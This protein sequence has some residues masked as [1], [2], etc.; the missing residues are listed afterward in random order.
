MTFTPVIE[1]ITSQCEARPAHVA[2]VESGCS[3]TYAELGRRVDRIAASLQRDGVRVGDSVALCATSTL[4]YVVAML[5]VLRCGAVAV[6][7][8]TSA[9]PQVLAGLVA[10]CGARRVFVDA[11]MAVALAPLEPPLHVPLTALDDA[12]G[13]PPMSA[14]LA[15]SGSSHEP[16]TH[17]ADAP[18]NIIYSSGT[19]GAPKG[20]VHPQDLRAAQVARSAGLGYGA[21]SVTLLATPLYSNITLTGLYPTLALGGTVVL[22]PKF[23]ATEYLQLAQRW[24][25]TQ[26]V[27]VSV[28]Y[29]RIL[30]QP[31]FD[32]C[33][34]S[35]FELKIAVGAPSSASL[36]AE[37]L[38]RWPGGLVD[39]YGLTEGGGTCML[40]AHEH[41]NK[42][43]TV[44]RPAPGHE[45]RV[46]DDAGVEL[47]AGQMGEVVGHS[48]IMMT[49]YHGLPEATRAAEWHDTQG[50][51]FIRTG[52]L[53]RFDA[54][55]F[56]TLVD[57]K[58]DMIISGG[59]NLYPSDIEAV[60]A[61]HADVA[62]AA[63][64]G[65]PSARWGETPVAFVV[66]R[67]GLS[68]DAA[69]LLAWVNQRVGKTQRLTAVEFVDGLPRGPV[70][71]VLKRELRERWR[72]GGT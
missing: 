46:V 34:L 41:P 28:Q 2:L 70:G 62:E 65:V 54:D 53:G 40:M 9:T 55:G 22:M 68:R 39:L 4:E 7:L 17:A 29:Q 38:Q 23:D 57:R 48:P 42:L 18:F 60:L 19:T 30:A 49:G 5:G 21:D 11:P 56:L 58:K 6:P 13:V 33:D 50:K 36:K 14:W 72:G 52:D 63:V 24:R 64:V 59:F 51:R 35:A 8:P 43:H 44:G 71:K 16:V 25:V 15:R 61:Q 12:P 31:E 26:T 47:P 69:A 66:L 20:I 32:A 37:L 3:I 1:Q 27:L 10:D 67:D 45:L